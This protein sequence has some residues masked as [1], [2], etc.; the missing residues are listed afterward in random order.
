MSNSKKTIATDLGES[1]SRASNGRIA[2]T[3]LILLAVVVA[4]RVAWL[5]IAPE[6][7]SSDL[8]GWDQMADQMCHGANPYDYHGRLNY[9]PFWLEVMYAAL[10]FSSKLHLS[11]I[12]CIRMVLI[13]GD[14]ALLASTFWLMRL[15]DPNG[16]Q[17]RILLVGYC[18]SPMLILLT[19]Q[20]GNFDA[21]VAIWA[22][23]LCCFLVR[24]RHS[25]EPEDWLLAAA[26]MGIGIFVKT[27]PLLLWPLLAC[28]T[29]TLNAKTLVIGTALAIGPPMLSMLPVYVLDPQPITKHVLEYRGVLETF[30]VLSF[31]HLS[32]ERVYLGE[33]SDAF[34]YLYLSKSV[35]LAAYL[36]AS[37][38]KRDCDLSLLA[39]LLFLSTGLFGAGYATQ[40][41]FWVVPFLLVCY[42]C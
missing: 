28:R 17:F 30:G 4:T 11:F 26:C 12:F 20:H 13:A 5:L 2:F 21:L 14:M 33:Y 38:L 42:G 23:L 3:L 29:K 37:D 40:H 7:M 34:P 6:S 39:A 35:L 24:Y 1:R 41:R 32:S 22:V 36:R 31:F 27:V 9:F 8:I 19:V 15:I 16:R 10:I 18:L 25:G